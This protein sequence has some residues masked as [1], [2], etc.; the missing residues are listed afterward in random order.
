MAV[1]PNLFLQPSPPSP[2]TS[3]HIPFPD[4]YPRNPEVGTC[5][6]RERL[7]SSNTKTQVHS[8]LH[9]PKV[10]YKVC[11]LHPAGE[12]WEGEK[13]TVLIRTQIS[14]CSNPHC[15]PQQYSNTGLLKLHFYF[16]IIYSIMHN[17]K[18]GKFPI[19]VDLKIQNSF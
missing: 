11:S 7:D 12:E 9:L 1:F 13:A 3:T 10:H 15:P 19:L 5:L 4:Q 14:R 6:K 8:T 17:V 2:S 16:Q 18:N